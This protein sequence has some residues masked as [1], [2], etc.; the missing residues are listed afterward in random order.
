MELNRTWPIYWDRD[1]QANVFQPN[2]NSTKLL[3]EE[4]YNVPQVS[5][6][7]AI[8]FALHHGWDSYTHLGC[9]P[10]EVELEQYAE[11]DTSEASQAVLAQILDAGSV[12]NN[13]HSSAPA[14]HACAATVP[15]WVE[16]SP[17]RKWMLDSGCGF[18]L[19][20]ARDLPDSYDSRVV[21]AAEPRT[22]HTANGC[23]L[24]TSPSPRD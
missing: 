15:G 14:V 1:W 20:S 24:Y 19:V 11:T 7:M 10:N 9:V 21:R 22:F 4:A 8:K 12:D 6:E 5:R 18:D 2:P 23:L 16:E 3:M 17:I 13:G